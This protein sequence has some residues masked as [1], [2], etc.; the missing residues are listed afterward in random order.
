MIRNKNKKYN[1]SAVIPPELKTF[2]DYYQNNINNPTYIR[3]ENGLLEKSTT[4]QKYTKITTYQIYFSHINPAAN[5]A[6]PVSKDVENGIPTFPKK[7]QCTLELT[8]KPPFKENDLFYDTE[9]KICYEIKTLNFNTTPK[10]GVY[11]LL[12]QEIEDQG[13]IMKIL[14][15]K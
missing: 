13:S 7:I 10:F 15:L 2:F 6:F 1:I 12:L 4:E 5:N 11:L 9:N 3:N 14:N 8:H